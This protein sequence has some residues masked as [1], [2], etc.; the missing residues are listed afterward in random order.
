M[1]VHQGTTILTFLY[2]WSLPDRFLKYRQQKKISIKLGMGTK[3]QNLMLSLNPLKNLPKKL[4]ATKLLHTVIK[5]K[6]SSF[7]FFIVNFFS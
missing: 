1:Y 2:K 7:H 4:E 3:M 5:V 6:N